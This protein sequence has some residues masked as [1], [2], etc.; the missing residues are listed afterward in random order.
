M[1]YIRCLTNPEG[2]YIIQVAGGTIQFFL[3][4]GEFVTMPGDD[5]EGILR[6]YVRSEGEENSIEGYEV[7]KFG[8]ATLKFLAPPEQLKFLGRTED[9]QKLINPNNDWKWFLHYPDWEKPIEMWEVTLNYIAS[10]FEQEYLE[11]LHTEELKLENQK[12]H[13]L[14]DLMTPIAE[15]NCQTPLCPSGK[16]L[17][18]QAR[19][20]L[21]R[22]DGVQEAL[23]AR[24]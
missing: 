20:I 22:N 12:L 2:L 24:K 14:L 10:R 19:G 8:K 17:Y 13:S 18:C 9:S 1:S 15:C 3:Q 5:F 16:C 11:E 23:D 7:Y 4:D 6:K 21:K